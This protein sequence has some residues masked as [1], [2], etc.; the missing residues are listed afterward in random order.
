MSAQHESQVSQVAQNGQVVEVFDI[1]GM[2]CAACQARVQKVSGAVD[3]V[4]HASVNLLKNSMEVTYDGNPQTVQNIIQAVDKAGYGAMPRHMSSGIAAVDA[5]A[6]ASSAE[7]TATVDPAVNAQKAIDHKRKQLIWSLVFSIPLFYVAMGPMF[8]WPLPFDMSATQ[9]AGV[10][11]LLQLVLA[12]PVLLVN[13]EYFVM[14]F[15]SLF[16]RAPNMDALIALGS[17]ASYVYSVISLFQIMWGYGWSDTYLVLEAAHKLYF[18]SAGMILT[19]ITLGKFFEARAKGKTTTAISSLMDLAPKTA[20][21]VRNGA[22]A[23]IP[24]SQVVV[25]DVLVVRTGESVPVDGTIVDGLGVLDESAITGE[26]IPVTKKVGEQVIGAT[27]SKAGWFTM[28][29]DAVGEDTALAGIIRLV[30]E[31]TNTK[32]PIQRV[33]DSIAGV[34]VPVVMVIAALTFVTWLVVF[35][36]GDIAT[37]LNYA[38]SVLVISCPCALGLATPTAIMVGTGRGAKFGILIKGAEA[39][40]TAGTLDVVVFDKTGT[41][42]EGKPSVSSVVLADDTTESELLDYA[43]AIE[44]KSEHPLAGAIVA[45]AT[46]KLDELASFGNGSRCGNAE[47]QD[48]TQIA[49]AGLT[50]H[51][52]DKLVHAG[53]ARHMQ[54]N[55]VDITALLDKANQSMEQGATSLFFSV[56]GRALGMIAVSDAIK[57]Q[58]IQAI[59]HLHNLGLRAIMLTGDQEKTARVVAQSV[60]VD[61][62]IASVLPNQKEHKI[63]ELQQSG[64]RVA[65]VGD[66]IND[67]PA[68]ARADVGI[69]IGAGTDVAIN[70]AD[71]VLMHSNPAD[72]ATAIELSRAT[73]TNIRQNLFWALFY[74]IICIPVAMGVLVPFGITLNPMIGALAMGFSSVFVVTNALRLFGWKPNVKVT[75]NASYEV[76]EKGNSPMASKTLSIDGMMCQHCAAHV[77]EALEGVHG[78]KNVVVSLDD[79]TATLDAGLLVSDAKLMKAVEDAG[80]KVTSIV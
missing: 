52:G 73:M 20:T 68:L 10:R 19:L 27:I 80:Y 9:G 2:T 5:K 36:P 17:A 46:K 49:G 15:K 54:A 79:K 13:R 22:E 48:F 47:V 42:T 55:G 62:V 11:A 58:S 30:D 18:D 31:A 1:E 3:G 40:E 16:H 56:D 29:A 7:V 34:F 70:S 25:G 69:A 76:Q 75:S 77:T 41:I 60:G 53:N 24:T 74:N 51:I 21:V 38:V 23:T 26:S 71:I 35:A 43:L 57:S 65:M 61:E 78:V 14:G 4:T 67:A 45:Y 72:V 28:R 12:T 37:A 8:G 50:A 33:A 6:A 32:A 44:S 63:R 59:N 64:K 66:G 39:L